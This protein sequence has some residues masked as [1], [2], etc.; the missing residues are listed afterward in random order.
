MIVSVVFC[1]QTMHA[2]NNLS[3][4]DIF[5]LY[6]DIEYN[7]VEEINHRN[8]LLFNILQ[9]DTVDLFLDNFIKQKRIVR[10]S[11]ISDCRYPLCD[12]IDLQ[13]CIANL[14]KQTRRPSLLQKFLK[15]LRAAEQVLLPDT[16]GLSLDSIHTLQNGWFKAYRVSPT[17][18]NNETNQ[19]NAPICLQQYDTLF[20]ITND[21]RY[22][23]DTSIWAYNSS[24][25]NLRY[26][27]NRLQPRTTSQ[28]KTRLSVRYDADIPSS[29]IL[30]TGKDAMF[31]KTHD[32]PFAFVTAGETFALQPTT[33]NL[34]NNITLDGFII[35]DTILTLAD[36]RLGQ[37]PHH[38]CN[39]LNI[40]CPQG[41]RF[42]VLLNRAA[43]MLSCEAED[44][45]TQHSKSQQQNVEGIF[46][47]FKKN[48]LYRIESCSHSYDYN[49]HNKTLIERIT[50][51]GWIQ[52]NWC[53]PL[54]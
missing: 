50:H 3:N 22:F 47:S 17:T 28:G 21:Q 15:P 40:S 20:I 13:K 34:E 27:F 53:N 54:K 38:V 16:D 48:A 6:A 19:L 36:L 24:V 7:T 35:T 10:E 49:K 12:I 29:L 2:E 14:Q 39:L 44:T 30:S 41:I 51:S 46:L 4:K 52:E 33:N 42:I 26:V 32:N 8:E 9:S 43:I 45:F 25:A 11:I 18:W 37:S 31:Y 5:A 1:R 23:N